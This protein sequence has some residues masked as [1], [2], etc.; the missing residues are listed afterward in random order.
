MVTTCENIHASLDDFSADFELEFQKNAITVYAVNIY[1][2]QAQR[3]VL[4][5]FAYFIGG[6]IGLFFLL[7]L[8]NTATVVLFFLLQGII[9]GA[10][11]TAVTFTPEV[12]S[13]DSRQFSLG[14]LDSLSKVLLIYSYYGF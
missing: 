13:T 14:L 2:F 1:Y 7:N 4:L 11:A 3:T 8:P 9:V 6:S 12:F 5:F 10:F